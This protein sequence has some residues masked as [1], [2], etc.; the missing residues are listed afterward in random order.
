MRSEKFERCIKFILREEGGYSDNPN[1]AGNWTGGGRGKGELKGTNFGISA[2]TYPSINIK[3][4]TVEQAKQ[5]YWEDYWQFYGIE[6]YDLPLALCVMDAYVNTRPSY[7][8]TW[9]MNNNDYVGFVGER[10][11]TYTSFKDWNHF[12]KGWA[13]RLA[14]CL[15]EANKLSK[16][17]TPTPVKPKLSVKVYEDEG[18]DIL[19]RITPDK[20]VHIRED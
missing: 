15:R 3:G 8:Q 1:D 9:L 12:G 7:V 17:S 20:V 10:L 4:L 2:A 13:A 14:R 19:I 6:Q 16:E 18:Q 5:I 11:L